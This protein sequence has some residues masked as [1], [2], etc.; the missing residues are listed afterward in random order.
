VVL[1]DNTT[2]FVTVRLTANQPSMNESE[3]A[4]NLMPRAGSY[5]NNDTRVESLLS[6]MDDCITE[7]Q[8]V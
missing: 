1:E 4:H 8:D 6:E 5:P 3:S 2:G 7:V